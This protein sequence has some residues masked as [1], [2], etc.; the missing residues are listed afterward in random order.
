[1]RSPSQR[2]FTEGRFPIQNDRVQVQ[3]VALGVDAFPNRC[4]RR[5]TICV[6]SCAVRGENAREINAA[7]LVLPLDPLHY[8]LLNFVSLHSAVRRMPIRLKS[9]LR[10]K[11]PLGEPNRRFLMKNFTSMLIAISIF[12]IGTAPASARCWA[13]KWNDQGQGTAPTWSC[14]DTSSSDQY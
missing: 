14:D 2:G 3:Q 9:Q 8:D 13:N 11:C 5:N 12:M 1:M 10:G 4:C 7:T 6:R